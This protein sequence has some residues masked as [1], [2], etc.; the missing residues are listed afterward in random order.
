MTALEIA[1]EVEAVAVVVQALGSSLS[2][3]LEAGSASREQ[4]G[5]LSTS[6]SSVRSRISTVRTSL[7]EAEVGDWEVYDDPAV[8]LSVLSWERGLRRTLVILARVAREL[9]A[10]VTVLVEGARRRTYVVR[11]VDS[12]QSIA[13]RFLGDWREWPR[14]AELNGLDPGPLTAGVV[15]TLPDKR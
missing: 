11:S 13:G 10:T 7:D 3:S 2:S 9:E 5:S 8:R 12:L 1:A 14:I 15:L 4:L 6:L